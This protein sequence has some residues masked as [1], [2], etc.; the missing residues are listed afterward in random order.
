MAI[1]GADR[2]IATGHEDQTIC[3]WRV[4]DDLQP[5]LLR[6]LTGHTNR[7]L[8]VAFHPSKPRLASSSCDRTI[9]LWD[10][11]GHRT[12]TLHG[13]QSWV[14]SVAFA[15]NG[16]VL[17]SGSYDHSVRIWDTTTGACLHTLTRAGTGAVQQ[18][19]YSPDGRWLASCGYPHTINLWD[20]ETASHSRQLVGHQTRVWSMGWMGSDLLATGSEDGTI[21][22]W[23]VATGDCLRTWTAHNCQVFCLKYDPT[24]DRLFSSDAKGQLKI[25]DVATNELIVTLDAHE[26]WLFSFCFTPDRRHLYSSSLDGKLKLWDLTTHGCLAELIPPRPYEGMQIAGIT[27]LNDAEYN[28]L[29]TLGANASR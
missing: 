12:H 21:C 27:G 14:W 8:S 18:V 19:S 20:G 1:A 11:S 23:A 2:L 3:L 25:W 9:A 15:P 16:R 10:T 13:H 22:L 26:H 29:I 4:D 24:T 5:Q 6:K 28:T 7:V 17:A